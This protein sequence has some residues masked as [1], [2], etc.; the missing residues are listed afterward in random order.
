MSGSKSKL[1][2]ILTNKCP[3][4]REG[5]FFV[6]K[7]P[8]SPKNFG[9]MHE[10]CPLCDQKYT[11]EP[12]FYF[13]AAYISYGLNVLLFV[14]AVII[15]YLFVDKPTIT[16]YVTAIILPTIVL[17]PLLFRL[18]RLIWAALFIPYSNKKK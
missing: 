8:Y 14:A 6:S 15:V 9:K 1:S 16:N 11:I 4:C 5:D 10:N 13:G 18:S 2:A 3:A 7:N 12:G 17:V